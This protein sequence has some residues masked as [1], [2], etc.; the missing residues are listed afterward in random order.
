[1]T[2]ILAQL[3]SLVSYGNQ[4]LIT[5]FMPTDYIVSANYSIAARQLLLASSSAWVFGGMGSWNDLSFE[6]EE[7][8]Q[9]YET[10]STALYNAIN[11]G[12]LAATNSSPA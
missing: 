9:H 4:S 3:V 12:I 5:G 8:N 7:D 2:G 6:K 1:M 11:R 10:L